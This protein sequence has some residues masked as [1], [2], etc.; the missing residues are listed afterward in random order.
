LVFG[1][2]EFAA[3]RTFRLLG[4]YAR[5]RG[6]INAVLEPFTVND[7]GYRVRAVGRGVPSR[8]V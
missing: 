1:V 2:G 6:T 4:P 3:R 8:N 5:F 7:L